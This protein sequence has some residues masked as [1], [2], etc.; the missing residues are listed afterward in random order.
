MV[1]FNREFKGKDGKRQCAV[2]LFFAD[3]DQI[4]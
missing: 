4:S 3:T 1:G 2:G